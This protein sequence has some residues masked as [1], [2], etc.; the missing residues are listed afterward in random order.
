MAHPVFLF[1]L[2]GTLADTA[3]DLVEAL[4]AALT[5]EDLPV[6]NLDVAR[7]WVAGGSVRLIAEGFGLPEASA[8]DH[9]AR[10]ALL[11]HYGRHICKHTRLFEGI[12]ELLEALDTRGCR[13]GIVTN[14]PTVYTTPL[15]EALAL[16]RRAAAIVSGD[17]LPVSKPDPAPLLLA[18]RQMEV[19]PGQ[20]IYVGDDRRDVSAG[21]AAGMSTVAVTWGYGWPDEIPHWG[22][23]QVVKRPA[24]IL[25]AFLPG[26]SD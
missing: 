1:D 12:A 10:T 14:K 22:A 6:V 11:D 17:T 13:W 18:C 15:L 5:R 9:P 23:D 19:A 24:E 25:T 8:R 2:D 21:Q 20:C 4:N 16:D 7:W 26:N 3:P